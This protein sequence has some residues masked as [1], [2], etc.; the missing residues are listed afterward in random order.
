MMI[1]VIPND[2]ISFYVDGKP[3][4][5]DPTQIELADGRE[6]GRRVAEA[7]VPLADD[8]GQGRPFARREARRKDA[9]GSVALDGQALL[10]ELGDHAGE[11]QVVVALAADVLVTQL[12]AEL[13]V[14]RR[15]V[16]ARG[17]GEE[18]PQHERGL[19]AGLEQH[20]TLP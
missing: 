3:S 4:T 7:A 8:E 16:A 15:E 5:G 10:L 18:A 14:D 17:A 19:V 20:D 11:A 6:I 1:T 13:L 2:T 9:D 12:H